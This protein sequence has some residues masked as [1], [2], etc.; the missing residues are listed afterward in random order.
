MNRPGKNIS[1]A[2]PLPAWSQVEVSDEPIRREK[3]G[4]AFFPR[5]SACFQYTLIERA[6]HQAL[7]NPTAPIPPLGKGAKRARGRT[8]S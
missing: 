2:S 8:E 4:L 5:N 1:C 6:R 7:K 3:S